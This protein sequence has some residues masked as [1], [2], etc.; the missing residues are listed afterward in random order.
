[1]Q[2]LDIDLLI[3][4]ALHDPSGFEEQRAKLIQEAIQ[5][6]DKPVIA[7]QLQTAV[8]RFQRDPAG[9]GPETLQATLATINDNLGRLLVSNLPNPGNR[10]AGEHAGGHGTASRKDGA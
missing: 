5:S 10:Q 3:R 8:S 9:N 1:M 2:R 6:C 7:Q 4:M